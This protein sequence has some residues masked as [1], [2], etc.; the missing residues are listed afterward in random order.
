MAIEGIRSRGRRVASL[1]ATFATVAGSLI[2]GLLGTSLLTAPPAGAS[3]ASWTAYAAGDLSNEAVV[4]NNV[5]SGSPSVGTPVS[6]GTSTGPFGVA[7][8]PDDQYAFMSNCSSS[9]LTAINTTTNTATSIA[10]LSGVKAMNCPSAISISPDGTQLWIANYYSVSTKY[11]VDVYCVAPAGCGATAF[12]GEI[13]QVHPPS[14][15]NP[16]DVAISPNGEFAYVSNYG[17]DTVSIICAAAAGCSGTAQYSEMPYSPLTV[18][19]G[20]ATGVDWTAFTPDGNYAY[21]ADCGNTNCNVAG[22]IALVYNP[23]SSSPAVHAVVTTN[24]YGTNQVDIAPNC[25]PSACAMYVTNFNYGGQGNV[26]VYANAD[27][28]AFPTLTATITTGVYN[29]NYFAI[30][31]DSKYL[32]VTDPGNYSQGLTDQVD[33]ISAASD[34]VTANLTDPSI[35]APWGIATEPDPAPTASFAAYPLA[36]GQPSYFDGSASSSPVGTV[37]NWAWSFGDGCTATTT[38]PTIEFAYPS[39]TGG[40]CPAPTIVGAGSVSRYSGT[41]SGASGTYSVNLTVT[42]SAGTSTGEVFTG[43]TVSN[44][45]GSSAS[46]TTTITLPTKLV[47][48]AASTSGV[49]SSTPNIGSL[50]VQMETPG[51]AVVN[52]PPTGPTV[53][54]NL[55]DGGSGGTFSAYNG[56]SCNSSPTFTSTTYA[57]GGS[58]VALCYG[59][60]T[61]G[62]YTLTFS[63]AGLT[64]ATQSVTVAPPGAYQ[65]AFGTSPESAICMSFCGGPTTP[66]MGPITVQTENAGGSA[67]NAGGSGITVSLS[68]SSG[69][70]VFSAWNGTSCNTTPLITSVAIGSAQSSQQICYGDT[71]TGTPTLTLATTGLTVNT[72]TQVETVAGPATQTVF[73]SAPQSALYVTSATTDM[74]PIFVS[75]E[76]A[77]GRVTQAT[78]PLTVTMTSTTP[79][80][81]GGRTPYFAL[82]NGTSCATSTPVSSTSASYTLPSGDSAIQICYGY[83]KGDTNPVLTATVSGL[84]AGTQT[85]TVVSGPPAQLVI[86]TAAVSGAA[87]AAPSIGPI[88]IDTE[89]AGGFYSPVASA[90]TVNLASS[91]SSGTF[92]AYTGGACTSTDVTSVVIS[93]A[94]YSTQVCYGDTKVGSPEIEVAAAG[95]PYSSSAPS[96]GG[97]CS[98]PFPTQTYNTFCQTETVTNAPPAVIVFTTSSITNV[99]SST[100]NE[101][102]IT[103]ELQDQFGNPSNAPTSAYTVSLSSTSGTGLFSAWN[104]TSCSSSTFTS[105]TIAVNTDSVPICYGDTKAG[106]PTITATASGT[107][108][109]LVNVV[110]QGETVN[111]LAPSQ[112][113]VTTAAPS[114]GPVNTTSPPYTPNLGPITATVEDQY[115]NPT[116]PTSTETLN[117]TW[118]VSGGPSGTP[119]FSAWNGSSCDTVS[120]SLT[121]Y[122]ISTSATDTQFCFGDQTANS[123]GNYY[124]V[125]VNG[126]GW[127]TVTKTVTE[128]VAKQSWLANSS[129]NTAEQNLA[130]DYFGV[131]QQ[132][133]AG[134][135]TQMVAVGDDPTSFKDG[136][137]HGEVSVSNGPNDSFNLVRVFDGSPVKADSMTAVVSGTIESVSCPTASFCAAVDSAGDLATYAHGSSSWSWTQSSDGFGNALVSVSCASPSFCVA[138]DDTGRAFMWGGSSWAETGSE[139]ETFPRILDSV[140]CASATACL[141]VDGAS[142]YYDIYNGSTWTLSTSSVDN[143]GNLVA[144]SCDSITQCSAIDSAGNILTGTLSSTSWS[145]I[146]TTSTGASSFPVPSPPS[147]PLSCAWGSTVCTAYDGSGYIYSNVSGTWARTSATYGTLTAISCVEDTSV[148]TT[149]LCGATDNAG[150]V[151]YD[152]AGSP[153]AAWTTVSSGSISS[154][155]GKELTALSCF[156]GSDCMAGDSAGNALLL[157]NNGSGG[158]PLLVTGY[159]SGVSCVVTSDPVPLCVAVGVSSS[160]GAELL[161]STDPS[162]PSSWTAATVPS[163]ASTASLNGVSCAPGSTLASTFCVI[164][165]SGAGSADQN[166]V[167]K[168]AVL[169]ETTNGGS[170]WT[171]GS[172]AIGTGNVAGGTVTALQAVSCPSSSECYAA[173]TGYYPTDSKDEGV[174]VYYLSSAWGISAY[175]AASTSGSYDAISCATTSVC[176]GAGDNGGVAVFFASTNATSTA[177]TWSSNNPSGPTYLFGASCLDATDCYVSGV[178]GTGGGTVVYENYSGGTWTP[179]ISESFQFNEVMWWGI[180][181]GSGLTCTAVGSSTGFAYPVAATGS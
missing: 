154:G 173:G 102:P 50:T 41:V 144:V 170:T 15:A 88:T 124:N 162:D 156:T 145:S 52:A 99:A 35:Y 131:S 2:L 87:S 4:L 141:G 78:S 149:I 71:A 104:G 135:S 166:T 98:S 6:D 118:S 64:S 29:P 92:S 44:D 171:D 117:I 90:Q 167:S 76:D 112:L 108:T 67:V 128:T 134:Q 178:N 69:T 5:Q 36:A 95:N 129:S 103:L 133:T 107:P 136:W 38:G 33:V 63:S 28:G 121:T 127:L 152:D 49:Q 147:T 137:G 114:G 175:A 101:G 113:V 16:I 96:N 77:S 138:L 116:K 84:T 34:T 40:A 100:P 18:T 9:S 174:T 163:N 73:T 105:T 74:G 158:S 180:N 130:G 172:L 161:V 169:L 66:N 57:T 94:T 151:L 142:G 119:V 80:T 176:A 10:S 51:G 93:A 86:S 45:G 83:T 13:T 30:T 146:T 160:G 72:A 106:T 122:S 123:T 148:T 21:V 85:E 153:T 55:S 177:A 68:S 53:T 81:G 47:V 39:S 159:L 120:S 8:T 125:N 75:L 111:P 59:N 179:T 139:N 89:D 37:T 165:G 61:S 65:I 79:G 42:N 157:V 26:Q 168:G 27:S 19:T 32:L 109:L 54:V 24:G 12:E 143:L 20:G 1:V 31:P 97:T 70:G 140:A 43:H 11:R 110:T 150:D 7:I 48:T 25:S 155:T 60:A 115:G 91:S 58:S 132:G 3:I 56:T 14:L 46:T 22:N 17:S 126:S 164:V 62:L 82:Y 23:E 181:C